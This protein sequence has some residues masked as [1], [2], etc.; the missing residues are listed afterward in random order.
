M[1]TVNFKI[2][3]GL[4]SV[5]NT[6]KSNLLINKLTDL[7]EPGAKKIKKCPFFFISII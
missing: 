6:E 3:N 1:L 4:K 2:V 5:K 7:M